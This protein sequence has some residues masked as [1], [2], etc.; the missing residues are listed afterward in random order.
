M[1]KKLLLILIIFAPFYNSYAAPGEKDV[2]SAKKAEVVESTLSGII[3]GDGDL[4]EAITN[5]EIELN[6]IPELIFYWID[7]L[8]YIIGSLAVLMIIIGGLQ[9]MVGSVSDEKERGKKTMM[10]ALVGVFVAFCS[11]MALNWFQLWLTS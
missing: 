5:G 1:K 9:Y 6:H 2:S 8:T 4:G 3:P 7:Y 10:Y 11:W